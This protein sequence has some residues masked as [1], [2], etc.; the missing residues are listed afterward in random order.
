MSDSSNLYSSGRIAPYIGTEGQEEG[1]YISQ[2]YGVPIFWLALYEEEEIAMDDLSG[3]ES[4]CSP[5]PYLVTTAE[6]AISRLEKRRGNI[7]SALPASSK[8]VYEHF[9]STLKTV[10]Q[11]YLHMDSSAV[12]SMVATP[13]EWEKELK[14]M[15]S[16]FNS[17]G[18]IEEANGMLTKLFGKKTAFNPGWSQMLMR[19]GIDLSR[20]SEISIYSLAGGRYGEMPWKPAPSFSVVDLVPLRSIPMC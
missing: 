17:P 5:Y 1:L 10:D 20:E 6:K 15:I 9:L 12:G 3:E 16:G 19:N 7:F 4:C 18:K 2:V 11:K 14:I 13:D 8:D